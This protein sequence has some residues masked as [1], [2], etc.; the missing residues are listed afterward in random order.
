MFCS[1]GFNPVVLFQPL[2][3]S[4]RRA[5]GTED[6]EWWCFGTHSISIKWST[7]TPD[8][9]ALFC[10]A[11]RDFWRK[12]NVILLH[13]SSKITQIKRVNVNKSMYLK[14]TT[15]NVVTWSWR[16]G[17]YIVPQKR[18]PL[19]DLNVYEKARRKGKWKYK[20]NYYNAITVFQNVA[21]TI[22]KTCDTMIISGSA[23]LLHLQLC[24]F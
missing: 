7:V 20:I 4:R 10:W 24:H 2:N 9:S 6:L 12:E 18:F 15:T 19:M 8:L 16:S 13:G 14:I 23:H 3:L 5:T 17:F 1:C 21:F 11:V 22:N